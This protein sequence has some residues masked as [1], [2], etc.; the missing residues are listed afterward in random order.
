MYL[1]DKQV[2]G[3]YGVS[4]KVPW[5]WIKTDPSFPKPLKLSPGCTRW[6]LEELLDWEQSRRAAA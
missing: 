2:A 1:S 3:R 5:D 6:K 4:R